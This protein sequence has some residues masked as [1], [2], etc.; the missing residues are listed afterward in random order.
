[1]PLPLDHDILSA[2]ITLE[3]AVNLQLVRRNARPSYFSDRIRNKA[4]AKTFVSLGFT[5]RYGRTIHAYLTEPAGET[6]GH[7]LGYLFPR[8]PVCNAFARTNI[9]WFAKHSATK[10]LIFMEVHT[11]RLTAPEIGK[12]LVDKLNLLRGGLPGWEVYFE[13]SGPSD[14]YSCMCYNIDCM[15]CDGCGPQCPHYIPCECGHCEKDGYKIDN[16]TCT[17]NCIDFGCAKD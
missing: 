16:H 4:A 17:I 13:I 14:T 9:R 5:V 6:T 15:V 2:P 3:D 7:K 1:M 11:S 8:N 10:L 12:P